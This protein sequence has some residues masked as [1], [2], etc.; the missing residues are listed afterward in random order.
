MKVSLAV[1]VVGIVFAGAAFLYAVLPTYVQDY[2]VMAQ[3]AS[4]F[5]WR[6]MVLGGLIFGL[7]L[8][9][10]LTPVWFLAYHHVRANQ[11]Q[12]VKR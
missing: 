5:G 1:A 3:A 6:F 4:L 11:A 2:R 12:E 7:G 8:A 9:G 10:G